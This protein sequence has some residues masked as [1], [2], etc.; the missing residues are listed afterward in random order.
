MVSQNKRIVAYFSRAGQNYCRGR[1]LTLEQGNT[2]VLAL[3]IADR[4]QCPAFEISPIKAY[5]K[6]YYA[7]TD[8]AKKELELDLRPAIKEPLPPAEDFEEIILCYPIW[9]GTVP[10]AVKTFL[11]AY[12]W[13]GKRI[14]CACTHEGSGFG[15]SLQ[16]LQE[17]YPQAQIVKGLSLQGTM[18]AKLQEE[19]NRWAES[20]NADK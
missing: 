6:E 2:E 5:P 17:R 20:L 18:V 15:R 9:W 19:I 4:L 3:A 1:V 16:D 8:L 14:V 7:C 12:D 13:E 11:D 10:M